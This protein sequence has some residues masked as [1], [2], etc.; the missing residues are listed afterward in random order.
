MEEIIS[1]GRVEAGG[2]LIENQHLRAHRQYTGDR[3]TPLLSARELKRRL[4]PER[5]AEAD[6]TQRF[7]CTLPCFCLRHALVLRTEHDVRDDIDLEE[8]IL[9]VLEHEAHFEAKLLHVELRCIDVQEAV[10]ADE[11]DCIGC[12]CRLPGLRT[13]ILPWLPEVGVVP[14][15]HFYRALRRFQKAVQ[16]LGQC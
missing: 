13:L 14:E 12:L 9:R 4:L 5:L 8:L 10:R 2:R 15:L 7:L 3:N 11:R 16:V 1:S 6:H